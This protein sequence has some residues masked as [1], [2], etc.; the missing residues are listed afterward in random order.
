M[1][2]RFSD[3]RRS[4]SPQISKIYADFLEAVSESNAIRPDSLQSVESAKSVDACRRSFLQQGKQRVYQTER[5]VRPGIDGWTKLSLPF[6][7]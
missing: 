3:P 4:L 1:S 5:R 6:C 2:T 7:R